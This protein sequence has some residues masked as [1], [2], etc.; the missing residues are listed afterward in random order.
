M[1][2]ATRVRLPALSL[3]VVLAGALALAPGT[4]RAEPATTITVDPA[5]PDGALSPLLFGANHRFGY[6]GFGSFDPK[7]GRVD[8]KLA[9]D[10]REA[11]VSAVRYPGGTIANLF[12]WKQAIG[13]QAERGCQVH[14]SVGSGEPLT[15]TYGPDEHARFAESIGARTN[16]VTNFATGTA[17]EAADWVEYMNAPVGTNPRGG[18][19]WARV[20]AKDGH[21]RPYGVRWWEVGNEMN[22]TGQSYWMGTGA[23]ATRAQKYAYGGTTAFTD[24]LVARPGCDR[25]PSASAG[26]G[27]AG[28]RYDV[29]YPPV[30]P[31]SLT[32]TVDG[33]AW[34]PVPDLAQA[35]PDEHVYTFEPD[36][37]RITFGGDGHGAAPADGAAIRA[38]YTSGPHQGFTAFADAMKAADPTIKVCSAFAD[39][40]FL[41]QVAGRYPLDCLTVH[42]YPGPAEQATPVAAH[43]AAMAAGDAKSAELADWRTRVAAATGGRGQIAVTE[44]GM[45]R[46]GYTGSGPLYFASLDQALQMAGQVATNI[47]LGVPI[48]ERHALVDFDPEAAPPGSTVL[49]G[50][51]QSLFGY[52]PSYVPSASALVFRLYTRMTGTVRLPAEITGNPLRGTYPALVATATRT[53][54][55]RVSLIV[56][57]RG[58]EADVTTRVTVPGTRPGTAEAWTVNGAS[59]T[60]VNTPADP[61]AVRLT[62]TRHRTDS[63]GLTYRFPAH[64]VTAITL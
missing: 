39:Q 48:A 2:S 38:S 16:I 52:A 34:R 43:D 25:R 32:V 12:R 46:G 6:D 31:D 42:N 13:P 4:A 41:D 24:Q 57:N 29:L 26:T 1:P 47:R 22:G 27:A 3:T 30:V 10:A 20:R 19:A 44:Y 36:T 23:V 62:Q 45:F 53:R 61:H 64:S 7:T 49:L 51:A 8:P 55:G 28:Q 50:P 56:A 14:G 17:D 15:S 37:G 60:S 33:A 5:R 18:V 35:G 59:T 9:R 58:P 21:P 40:A 54:T 11:G 63:G